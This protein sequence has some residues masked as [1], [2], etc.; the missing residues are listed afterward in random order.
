M[1]NWVLAAAIIATYLIAVGPHLD[2]PFMD[3]ETWEFFA[4]ETLLRD[5]RAMTVEG[6][7]N[8]FHP[9]GYY[10]MVAG[11]FALLGVHEVAA[12]LVGV[13]AT[14]GTFLLLLGIARDLRR[15]GPDGDPTPLPAGLVGWIGVL[16][17]LS[18]L[19]VQGS[20]V[21]TADT[22]VH[23]FFL[24]LWVGATLRQMPERGRSFSGWALLGL[25]SL[26]AL[27]FAIKIVSPVLIGFAMVV[28]LAH[29]HGIREALRYGFVV[30]LGGFTLFLAFWVPYCF[31]LDTSPLTCIDYLVGT[32]QSRTVVPSLA[33]KAIWLARQAT[34][35]VLWLG[36]AFVALLG[37]AL[38]RFSTWSKAWRPGTG[39]LAM[40]VS[41]L[42]LFDTLVAGASFGFPRYHVVWMPFAALFVAL[43]GFT[44]SGTAPERL[45]WRFAA[46]AFAGALAFRILLGDPIL[47]ATFDLKL[48][49][50]GWNE[51]PSRG[52]A[53]IGSTLA[54]AASPFLAAVA[55]AWASRRRSARPLPV[56]ALLLLVGLGTATGQHLLQ[57]RSDHHVHLGYG[58]HGTRELR[59]HVLARLE[60]G[61]TVVGSKDVVHHTSH[62]AF[63]PDWHWETR[64]ILMGRLRDPRTQFLVMAIHHNT[65]AQLIRTREDDELRELL[66]TEYV[67]SRIGSY[68]VWERKP[69]FGPGPIELRRTSG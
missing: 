29:T 48:A 56:V 39:M 7:V 37:A 44:L 61:R 38:L 3:D 45:G 63:M 13:L 17:L 8:V 67:A 2:T 51:W 30:V 68:L 54:L 50:L 52:L 41:V 40:I 65:L 12:R 31:E 66:S 33:A 43:A 36:F 9:H 5:G 55:V 60:P 57:R 28:T 58:E 1:T 62:F 10:T 20:L 34:V 64:P 14:I 53:S 22:A 6:D 27:C 19:V 11:S 15:R 18:P 24:T 35:V 32:A 47:A 46:T 4:S 26:C 16:Y 59:D 21:I 23:H 25:G 42:F 69:R 49:F